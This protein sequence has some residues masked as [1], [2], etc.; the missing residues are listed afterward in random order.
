MST[1]RFTGRHIA[2]LVVLLGGLGLRL[3]F[4]HRHAFLAGDSLLYQEIANNW[5]HTGVYGL[6]TDA[7][8]RP[9]LI[10]LPGYPM[11]LATLGLIFDPLLKADLGTLRSFLPVLYLQVAADLLTCG[12]LAC[13]A[14]KMFGRRAGWA[15][16][17]ISALCPFTANY[18]AVPLTETLTLLTVALSFWWA[19]RLSE[20]RRG[21]HLLL[22]SATLSFSILLR[23]DQGLLAAA[24]LPLLWNHGAASKELPRRRDFWRRFWR[25]FSPVLLAAA[26]VAAPFVPWTL[27]N[28][29]TFH[30]FQPLAPR[31]AND[32]GD[33]IPRGF[34]RWYRTF[35]VDFATTEDAYW[36][37]P[38]EPV[39]AND[40]PGRAFDSEAQRME[41]EELLHEA[42]AF[43]QV[44][45][46]I[47]GH[48]AA[49][50]DE[51]IRSHPFRYYVLLPVA[52][53]TNMLLHPRVEMLPV[54]DRWWRYRAHPGQTAFAWGYAALNLAFCV[55]ALAGLPKALRLRPALTCAMCAFV[56]LRC[57]LLLTL[58]NA[59]QR[60]TLEFFPVLILLASALVVPRTKPEAEST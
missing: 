25:G 27:R 35:A 28:L 52:R 21:R 19:Q 8:P 1:P 7:A 53:L 10:R 12:V 50:A 58:D 49:L 4:V 29:R 22:L 15:A 18:T 26:L 34:Q 38:E 30:V 37:Y 23:P 6:S 46:R 39:D 42:A 51:R 16:L 5:V 20:G 36:R 45:P 32:P 33:A 57:G 59:E 60:Y 9:T 56:L 3:F 13:L 11:V 41:T 47:D 2:L 14:R 54:D 44:S 48:F 17:V 43:N 55:A 40:L 24:V 31:F